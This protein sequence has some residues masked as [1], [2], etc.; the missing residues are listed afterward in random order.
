MSYIQLIQ[1]EKRV[2]NHEGALAYKMSAE[3]ELYTTVCTMALQPKFYESTPEQIDRV[4][5]LIPKVSPEF[6]AQLAIYARQEM[7]L[8]SVPL[9]LIVE[10]A[11]VHCGDNLVSNAIE[12]VILRADEITELLRCYQW[13]NPKEGVKK[14]SYLSHQVQKGL[15]RAF[16]KFDEYQFAKYNRSK[17]DISLRDALFIV[18]PKAVNK[19]QQ[20]LFDKIANNTLE[21][22][23]TWE[24]ELSALGQNSYATSEERTHIFAE[25][26]TEL[27]N[28]GK[29]G[30][31]ALLRN[32]RNIISIG[33]DEGTLRIVANRIANVQEIA[34]A[35]Q[36]P[37]RYLSA[38]KEIKN[39]DS[40]NTP[41]ILTALEQ[42]ALAS[43]SNVHGFSANSKVMIACDMSG[44]MMSSL[45]ARGKVKYYEIGLVLAMLLQNNCHRVVTGIFADEFE[46]V[47]LPQTSILESAYAIRQMIGKVGYGTDG[48]KPLEWL[49]EKG[50][51]VD[52]VVY[53][54]DC[55]FWEND[56]WGNRIAQLWTLYKKISPT[57]HLYLFDLA[58]YG[59]VPIQTGQQDIT[60]ISGWSDRIFDM[61]QA[62]ENEKDILKKIHCIEL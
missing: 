4:A 58:G 13:R 47:N 43:A 5:K 34:K 39:V 15:Q 20:L 26:W 46:V 24:T 45:S 7:L 2:V 17:K 56:Y 16:N 59:H 36:L 9:L 50:E 31:M 55:Q 48:N 41:V 62:I 8:R 30:Y 11:K 51:I 25:K 19:E 33:I 6:V 27:I 29:L 53:F 10:L 21:V 42:A 57:A 18:H 40:A 37:F 23:Y 61:L 49:I 12:K 32:L 22:P 3:A 44:S 35:Q 52:K 28:S 54:T 14:L 1:E 60:M 38:Y